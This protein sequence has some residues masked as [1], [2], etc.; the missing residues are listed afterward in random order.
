[1]LIYRTNLAARGE[2]KPY[3]PS[4]DMD[5]LPTVYIRPIRVS[6]KRKRR[7]TTSPVGLT[8]AAPDLLARIDRLVLRHGLSDTAIGRAALNDP[9]AVSALRNG[10][11]IQE[12]T[13]AR[14][15]QYLDKLEGRG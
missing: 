10:R 11:C 1:M 15:V 2:P 8:R 7:G 13:R 14:L 6:A 9:N 5:D 3:S 4:I 12:A